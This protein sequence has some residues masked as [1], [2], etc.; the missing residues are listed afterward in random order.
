M[1]STN[2]PNNMQIL[3][4]L[5][6]CVEVILCIKN[7]KKIKDLLTSNSKR[8]SQGWNTLKALKIPVYQSLWTVPRT[9]SA[10]YLSA[11]TMNSYVLCFI[12]FNAASDLAGMHTVYSARSLFSRTSRQLRLRYL[13]KQLRVANLYEIDICLSRGMQDLTELQ[14]I[15]IYHLP[16]WFWE[17]FQSRQSR[18]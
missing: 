3:I 13:E 14:E 15:Y 11:Y 9:Y 17:L 8:T 5:F 6:F 18:P 1:Q 12:C 4:F 7:Q 10:F 2:M 16:Y